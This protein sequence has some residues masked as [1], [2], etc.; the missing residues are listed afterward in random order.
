M[1]ISKIKQDQKSIYNYLLDNDNNLT[2]P[3]STRVNLKEYSLKLYKYAEQFW[4]IDNKLNIGF[5]ACYLNDSSLY[6]ATISVSESHKG[7]G[8][9]KKLLNT[10]ISFANENCVK[11]IHLEVQPENKNVIAFYKKF[12]F[13][14]KSSDSRLYMEL[15]LSNN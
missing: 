4:V 6:I 1:I 8:L 13:K 2:P 9:G 11:C 5:S 3:L 15:I 12:N 14:E 10:I 7:L